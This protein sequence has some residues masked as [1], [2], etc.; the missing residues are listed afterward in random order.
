MASSC[1]GEQ[2]L[3]PGNRPIDLSTTRSEALFCG[4]IM[5][6]FSNRRITEPSA[7]T[8]SI[9]VLGGPLVDRLFVRRDVE[10]IFKFRRQK[11]MELFDKNA[12]SPQ[13]TI[14]CSEMT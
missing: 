12:V 1:V 10:K 6:T 2:I 11:L 3:R 4:G 8:V 14:I 5:S 9:A 13:R 7:G